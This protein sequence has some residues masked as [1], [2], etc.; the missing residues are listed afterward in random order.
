MN[1][2]NITLFF[3]AKNLESFV[4][5]ENDIL[6]LTSGGLGILNH[7]EKNPQIDFASFGSRLVKPKGDF[8]KLSNINSEYYLINTNKKTL[9]YKQKKIIKPKKTNI[10]VEKPVISKIY[11]IIFFYKFF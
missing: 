7:A 1:L 2:R 5:S 3:R 4:T 8:S 6:F 10:L 9:V 11:N